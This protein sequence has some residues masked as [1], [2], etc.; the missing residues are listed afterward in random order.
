M[1]KNTSLTK[2]KLKTLNPSPPSRKDTCTTNRG[3]PLDIIKE[4]F[5][6]LS[7]MFTGVAFLIILS[8]L[9]VGYETNDDFAMVTILS[10][11]GG[12]PSIPDA[13]F[14]NPILSY[15]LFFLYKVSPSFP[16]YGISLYLTCYLG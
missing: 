10:G 8:T 7:F 14:L 9:P 15:I 2:K 13:I 1:L 11:K 16:W 3:F 4:N 5:F 6:I 12:F